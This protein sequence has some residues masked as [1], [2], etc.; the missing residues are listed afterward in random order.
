[1]NAGRGLVLTLQWAG[2]L[3]DREKS[4]AVT[5]V[6]YLLFEGTVRGELENLLV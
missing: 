3:N 4:G 6:V 2:I 5:F 1:M